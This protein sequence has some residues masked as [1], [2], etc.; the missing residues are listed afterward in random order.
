MLKKHKEEYKLKNVE[1]ISMSSSIGDYEKHVLQDKDKIVL[2]KGC[3]IHVRAA[4]IHNHIVL[5]SKY[6]AKYPLIR[7]GEKIRYY[8]V[9]SNKEE[10]NVFGFVAGS[11]PIE[12]APP[13]DINSQF[14]R[15]II[16]PINRFVT[17]MGFSEISHKLTTS[18]QL[19]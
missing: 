7:S 14:N 17:A 4:A 8:H 2:E 5:N 16:Q 10:D 6:K 13:I 15:S 11:F 19:F 9:Q 18:T 3:P 1:D 12:L